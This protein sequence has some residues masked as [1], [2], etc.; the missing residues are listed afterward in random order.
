[1]AIFLDVELAFTQGVPEFDRAVTATRNNLSVVCTE[2]DTQDVGC[3]SNKATSGLAG[4]E[5]PKAE[6]VVP[7]G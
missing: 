2:A 6:S 4:V 3:V 7:R 5:V 1:M